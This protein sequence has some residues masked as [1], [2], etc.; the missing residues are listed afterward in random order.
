MSES[1]ITLSAA[2]RKYGASVDF[3]RDAVLAGDLRPVHVAH[4]PTGAQMI[5]RRDHVKKYF[6]ALDASIERK[7]SRA[8]AHTAEFLSGMHRGAT[9]TAAQNRKGYDH[10]LAARKRRIA[11]QKYPAPFGGDTHL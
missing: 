5:F 11:A 4:H 9:M 3:I 6:D 10:W 1:V 2:A 7:N 8:G